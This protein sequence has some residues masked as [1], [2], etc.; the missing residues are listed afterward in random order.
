MYRRKEGY[1][2]QEGGERLARFLAHAGIASRRHA[3]E[4]IAAGRVQVNGVTITTQGTRINPGTDIVLVDHKPVHT[5]SKHVYLLLN[6]PV[7]YVTTVHD[8]QGRPTVLE[9]LPA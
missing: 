4:M 2:T 7:G 1:M 3:E 8:T 6:K 5:P 9:L